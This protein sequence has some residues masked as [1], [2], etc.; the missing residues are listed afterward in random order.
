VNRLQ[1]FG[2]NEV[3]ALAQV[4][5]IVSAQV[6]GAST[7]VL[8]IEIDESE[9]FRHI[10]LHYRGRSSPLMIQATPYLST[11][12]PNFAAQKVGLKGIVT[13]PP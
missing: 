13:R 10:T 8:F 4:L 11:S 5:P 1:G 12:M 7:A 9:V 3:S 2:R 6:I